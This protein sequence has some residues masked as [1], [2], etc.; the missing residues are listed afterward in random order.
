MSDRPL[1]LTII[2]G[3]LGAGKTTLINRLL[4]LADGRRLAIKVNDFGSL[5][6]DADLIEARDGDL[7]T[8]TGGCVCCSFGDDLMQSLFKMRGLDPAPDHIV[9]EASG[10]ALPGA[11]ASTVG[12]FERDIRLNGIV[13]LVDVEALPRLLRDTYLLDTVEN[14]LSA[15]HLFVLTKTDLVTGDDIADSKRLVARYAP[16]IP[17]VANCGNAIYDQVLLGGSHESAFWDRD[18]KSRD[19]CLETETL[20]MTEPVCPE[21]FGALLAGDPDIVRAKGH[22]VSVES[23]QLVTIQ[24]VGERFEIAPAPA[25]ARPGMVIIRKSDKSPE[26]YGSPDPKVIRT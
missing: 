20:P 26:R 18:G 7:V 13:V 25:A 5:P 11:I 2:S 19:H 15:A 1:P 14:Q 22:V 21:K 16:D 6:I 24:Q 3:Y 10:V 12:L 23:R 17:V 9:L 8:L 4:K